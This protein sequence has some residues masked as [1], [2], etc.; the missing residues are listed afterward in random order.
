MAEAG[1]KCKPPSPGPT[2]FPNEVT[3]TLD[4]LSKEYFS[5]KVG[6]LQSNNPQEQ[7]SKDGINPLLIQQE[8]MS[9][10]RLSDRLQKSK[11]D[12]YVCTLG[13]IHLSATP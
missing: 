11:D 3:L 13:C 1:F 4:L 5:F 12:V 10:Y 8:K 6:G 2:L 9:K 7:I